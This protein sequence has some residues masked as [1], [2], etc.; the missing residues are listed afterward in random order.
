MRG[1]P[2]K[3]LCAK[4]DKGNPRF[5]RYR[6]ASKEA[7]MAKKERNNYYQIEVVQTLAPDILPSKHVD[8]IFSQAFYLFL[9]QTML[10]AHPEILDWK[11]LQ[12]QC[13]QREIT[14]LPFQ[15]YFPTFDT[16]IS[17]ASTFADCTVYAKKDKMFVITEKCL[18][19]V[20]KT[21]IDEEK[22]C[23]FETQP[24][25]LEYKNVKDI[26][27]ENVE[28]KTFMCPMNDC[29]FISP[30]KFIGLRNH[31]VKKH[32]NERIEKEAQSKLSDPE[33]KAVREES[34]SQ[35]M[36]NWNCSLH[37]LRASGDLVHHYGIYHGM[38]DKFFNEFGHLQILKIF[39]HEV[40]K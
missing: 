39:C 33:Y 35:C 15:S 40:S 6:A 4:T 25:I 38:V 22:F 29:N 26:K 17:W 27:V 1:A 16:L 21:L 19:M 34:E 9:P 37:T 5:N 20:Q 24:T 14:S 13:Q 23:L 36:S 7:T 32:F 12:V 2:C 31:F 18:E 30:R 3:L 28:E 8:A 11:D 10:D